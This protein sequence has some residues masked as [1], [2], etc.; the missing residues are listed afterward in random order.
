MASADGSL[1]SGSSPA[2]SNLDAPDMG[3][4]GLAG[5]GALDIAIVRS[6]SS[7]S[8]ALG[9]AR[10]AIHMSVIALGAWTVWYALAHGYW[11]LLVPALV[12]EGFAIVTNFA[13]MH[14]CVH[15]TAFATPRL[16]EIC[17]WI[18]GLIG[19]Y[20]FHYYR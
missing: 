6:L 8:D 11:W 13:P 17:G 20:N 3:T 12:V 18:S 9:L 2:G 14:E 19:F 1:S 10:Y 5:R 15:R 7:R 4:S 16:N